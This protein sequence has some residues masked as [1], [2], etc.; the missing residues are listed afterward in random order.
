[1]Y[2]ETGRKTRKKVKSISEGERLMFGKNRKGDK[3]AARKM[4]HQRSLHL[5]ERE[6]ITC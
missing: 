3:R 4:A 5:S 1:M 6:T 2:M